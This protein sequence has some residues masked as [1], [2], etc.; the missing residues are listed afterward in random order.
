MVDGIARRVKG[1]MRRHRQEPKKLLG[2]DG[3][4]VAAPFCRD[5]QDAMIIPGMEE[6]TNPGTTNTTTRPT[7]QGAALMEIPGMAETAMDIPGMEEITN[8]TTTEPPILPG[9]YAA[10]SVGEGN[11]FTAPVAQA[12]GKSKAVSLMRPLDLARR[13]LSAETFQL[14]EE[15]SKAGVPTDCGTPWDDKVIDRARMAGPHAS[16]MTD[17]NIIL[18]WEDIGYQKEAGFVRIVSE[19]DLLGI[20]RNP[21]LKI[22]R[23][24]VVPQTNRRGRIILNLSAQ[25]DMGSIRKKGQ[26]R[27]RKLV[28]PSVNE[29][30]V[31]AADQAAVQDLGTARP[32][33]LKFMFEADCA[34]EIKL[35]SRWLHHLSHRHAQPPFWRRYEP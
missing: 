26:R 2:G 24:A 10:D 27:P 35:V 23:I 9:F 21:N 13:L 34:W 20:L 16:A 3:T 17:D 25:V 19:A 8:P 11:S 15:F 32:A 28:H 6:I 7:P 12:Q 22:S 5:A 1:P 30:T 33:L 14:L 31:P 18:I 29:T 4:S